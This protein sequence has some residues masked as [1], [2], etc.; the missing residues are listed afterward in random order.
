MT[1]RVEF[2]DQVFVLRFWQ[3]MDTRAAHQVI[4]WR[5]RITHVNTRDVIY[6]GDVERALAV[7]WSILRR[8]THSPRVS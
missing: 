1:R 6:A 7:V 5:A 3:E 8:S 4:R 2:E